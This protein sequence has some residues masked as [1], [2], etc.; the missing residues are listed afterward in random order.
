MEHWWSDVDGQ[1]VGLLERDGAMTPVELGRALGLSEGEAT[2]FLCML[3]GEGKVRIR[4]VEAAERP[5][6]LRRR[7]A[8]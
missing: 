7:A 1:I 4:L 8:A 3:A 5:E 2:A 6:S